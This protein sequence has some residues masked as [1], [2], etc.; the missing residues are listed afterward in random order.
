MDTTHFAAQ[1]REIETAAVPALPRLAF[2]AIASAD[3]GWYDAGLYAHRPWPAAHAPAV[4]DDHRVDTEFGY[5]IT[6][7]SANVP[8]WDWDRF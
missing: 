6:L 1:S 8:L 2:A 4:G 5:I 7:H 3:G